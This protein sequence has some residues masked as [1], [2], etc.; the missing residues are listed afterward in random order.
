MTQFAPSRS[1][2]Q[3]F[4]NT[5]F[6]AVGYEDFGDSDLFCLNATTGEV[7]WAKN[8]ATDLY[9]RQK[10]NDFFAACPAGLVYK[11]RDVVDGGA[12]KHTLRLLSAASGST[13]WRVEVSP[14]HPRYDTGDPG[15]NGA[16]YH[17]FKHLA[18]DANGVYTIGQAFD[19]TDGS[20]LWNI[21]DTNDV[22]ITLPTLLNGNNTAM[23]YSPPGY[24]GTSTSYGNFNLPQVIQDSTHVYVLAQQGRYVSMG[25]WSF[26]SQR[27][28]SIRKSDG[29]HAFGSG[30][31]SGSTVD[32]YWND[33]PETSSLYPLASGC[34]FGALGFTYFNGNFFTARSGQNNAPVY[35][36]IDGADEFANPHAVTVSATSLANMPGCIAAG[37][38]LFY[39]GALKDGVGGR[40][41]LFALDENLDTVWSAQACGPSTIAPNAVYADD[42]GVYVSAY[43]AVTTAAG[44]WADYPDQAFQAMVSKFDNDGNPVWGFN[45]LPLSVTE[46][47]VTVYQK[48]ALKLV[49]V[50]NGY[51]YAVCTN[52]TADDWETI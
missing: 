42:T 5:G 39:G 2:L 9:S 49:G 46:G 27:I 17:E 36:W 34:T 38:H 3:G 28:Y 10:E 20:A 14:A 15:L 32:S 25:S 7:V 13:T 52:S 29:L 18:A 30:R 47:G 44:I 37:E 35:K 22:S 43:P 6:Q 31:Y 1:A 45:L 4:V 40:D 16:I 41:N 26:L 50:S 11:S 12:D 23:A 51:V 24:Y 21:T 8:R 33:D 48:K 19:I